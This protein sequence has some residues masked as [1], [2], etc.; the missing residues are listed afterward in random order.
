MAHT[1]AL[2]KDMTILEKSE[3]A[4][5][6]HQYKNLDSSFAQHKQLVRINKVRIV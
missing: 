6:R 5:L 4:D 2:R 1:G 3:I